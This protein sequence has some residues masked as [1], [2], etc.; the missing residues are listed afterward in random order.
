MELPL[1]FHFQGWNIRYNLLSSAESDRTSTKQPQSVVFVHGTPWSSVVFQPLIETLLTKGSYQ[2]LVSKATQAPS[3]PTATTFPG[4]TSVKFQS[5]ALAALLSSVHPHPSKGIHSAG[6]SPS[7]PAIIAHDIAGAIVLRAHLLHGCDFA[8]MLLMDTNAVLPWGDGFYKLVRS[9][10]QTFVR[11]PPKIF[12]AV[13]RAVVQSACFDP[14]VLKTGWEDRLT[15]PWIDAGSGSSGDGEGR[16]MGGEGERQTSF[17]RQIAQADDRD[18][19]EMLDENMYEK[20]R[21]RVK[22]LWG[23]NDTW[24]PK[25]K[26]ERLIDMLGD[27]VK[28]V[29]FIPEAGHLVMLDQPGRVSVEVYDWLN[30]LSE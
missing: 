28:D 23:E 20:V 24:I 18:V 17:V 29:A 3:P 21:C 13:G 8:S 11:L 9:E 22:I 7:P 26:I 1:I 6:K 2:I 14:S 12:E 19:A 4:D 16:G 15:L 27:K 30:Q 10:P 5:E 25:G